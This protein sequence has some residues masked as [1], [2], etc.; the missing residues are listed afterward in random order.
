MCEYYGFVL[1][2]DCVFDFFWI[3]ID[4]VDCFGLFFRDV[5]DFVVVDIM[6][7]WVEYKWYFMFNYVGDWFE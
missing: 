5:V 1:I 2:I 7:V 3:G 6:I 4:V